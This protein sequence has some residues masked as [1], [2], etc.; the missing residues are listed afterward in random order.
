[1]PASPSGNPI[2]NDIIRPEQAEQI[3]ILLIPHVGQDL[4]QLQEWTGLSRTDLVNRAI[5]LYRFIEAQL[6]E[7]YDL[8]LRDRVTGEDQLIQFA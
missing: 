2:K 6:R 7:R 8:V 4:Q 3:T 5:T 1:M